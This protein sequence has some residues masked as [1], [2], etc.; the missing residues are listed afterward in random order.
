MKDKF[1]TEDFL[2]KIIPGGI[3]LGILYFLYGNEVHINLP[4]GLDVFV[5]VGRT[6]IILEQDFK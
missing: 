1:T 6:K 2:I 5:I 4:K 3:L